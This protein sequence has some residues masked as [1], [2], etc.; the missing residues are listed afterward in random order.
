[1]VK[2][3]CPNKKNIPNHPTK[4]LFEVNELTDD[5]RSAEEM[6][7]GPSRIEVPEVKFCDI[8]GRSYIK[9]ECIRM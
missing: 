4:I 6:S 7:G 9:R 2:W 5:D 8:C 1:M 3:K